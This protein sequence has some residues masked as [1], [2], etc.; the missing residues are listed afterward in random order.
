MQNIL[1]VVQPD[2]L[3]ITLATLHESAREC[4][5]HAKS[6]R[7]IRAYSSDWKH[8]VAFCKA[9]ALTHLPAETASIGGY[10]F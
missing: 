2:A 5:K 8:C 4:V 9:Q 3:D 10:A 6:E 1:N 7:T